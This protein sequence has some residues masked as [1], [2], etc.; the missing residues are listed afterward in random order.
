M[1]SKI[2]LSRFLP[3]W[4]HRFPAFGE[5]FSVLLR[6]VGEMTSSRE[7]SLDLE[8]KEPEEA[9]VADSFGFAENHWY[10]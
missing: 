10:A 5:R 7:K 6:Q 8:S 2:S 3:F 9:N 4:Q 1:M